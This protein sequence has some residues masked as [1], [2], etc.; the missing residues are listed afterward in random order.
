M[1]VNE[2]GVLLRFSTG[3]NLS[4]FVTLSIVFTKPDGSTFTRTNPQ[5]TAPNTDVTTTE[6]LFAA[7]TYAQYTF[8]PGDVDQAGVWCAHVV[9]DDPG[10]HLLSDPGHFTIDALVC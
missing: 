4:A 10:Q 3:F 2:W 5:V 9:Y 6:G 1:I 8:Q 7:N